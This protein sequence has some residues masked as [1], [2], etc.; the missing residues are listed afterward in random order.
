MCIGKKKKYG[1]AQ[2]L[3]EQSIETSRQIGDLENVAYNTLKLG[4]L[5]EARGNKEVALVR[6]REGLV[7]LKKN[8]AHNH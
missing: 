7:L 2:R 1:E 3:V 5:H 8:L 6:Y 4:Q